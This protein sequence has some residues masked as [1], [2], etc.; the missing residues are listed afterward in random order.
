MY[1]KQLIKWD[2]QRCWHRIHSRFQRMYVLQSHAHKALSLTHLNH[3]LQ[4]LLLRPTGQSPLSVRCLLG[5]SSLFLPHLNATRVAK[6][7]PS[8][9]CQSNLRQE[10]QRMQQVIEA[11]PRRHTK[12]SEGEEAGK[13]AGTT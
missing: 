9:I 12:K 6:R 4:H 3:A 10:R 5:H 2:C 11:M 8:E 1:A 7:T 13:A